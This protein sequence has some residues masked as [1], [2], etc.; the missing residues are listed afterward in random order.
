MEHIT[1]CEVSPYY[2]VSIALWENNK[3]LLGVVY[4]VPRGDMYSGIV[5]VGAWC[6]DNQ[7]SV[8]KNYM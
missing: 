3:P 6:N 8:S 1:I 2:A 4:D 5:G 7:M